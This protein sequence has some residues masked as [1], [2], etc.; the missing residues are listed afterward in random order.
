LN[1]QK[2]Y[3]IYV[4]C[5]DFDI[6]QNI[7][8]IFNNKKNFYFFVS[9]KNKLLLSLAGLTFFCL[10]SINGYKEKETLSSNLYK[11][12]EDFKTRKE[13]KP[14]LDLNTFVYLVIN[15][16]FNKSK[17]NKKIKEFKL[18][19]YYLNKYSEF[20]DL[21]KDLV[22]TIYK[23]ENSTWD[24]VSVSKKYGPMQIGIPEFN[25]IM[26]YYLKEK[27]KIKKKKGWLYYNYPDLYNKISE[28]IKKYGSDFIK[29]KY[30]LINKNENEK[31]EILDSYYAIS[32]AYIKWI[33]DTAPKHVKENKEALNL[34]TIVAYHAGKGLIDNLIK[35]RDWR[36]KHF[37][38]KEDFYW[39]VHL[40]NKSNNMVSKKYLKKAYH[41]L[42]D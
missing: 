40:L 3:N 20:F 28:V 31:K 29:L 30:S 2:I 9:L 39:I 24:D 10:D 14:Y 41:S 4:F 15:N 21:P 22:Y 5:L 38:N 36:Q 26:Y 1:K 16:R 35:K 7:E 17:M 32:L 18:D 23:L 37:L 6:I 12:K 27:G 33:R 19:S 34:Y 8:Q 25:T 42:L 13:V 11:S